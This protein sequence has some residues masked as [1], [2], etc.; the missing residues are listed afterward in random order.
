MR[1][2]RKDSNSLVTR[3]EAIK[4]TILFSTGMLAAGSLDL[5]SAEKPI[6]EFP[7]KGLHFLAFGD[8]GSGNGHQVAVAS[9]M[10]KFAQKLNTPLSGVLALGDNFMA[11]WSQNDSAGTLKKCT[12]RNI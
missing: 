6:T 1:M 11:N 2:I 12:A 5:L 8:F 10:A 9:Q 3:R 7:G 4:K